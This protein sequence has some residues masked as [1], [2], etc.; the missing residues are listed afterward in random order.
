M[1]SADGLIGATYRTFR[2]RLHTLCR[3]GLARSV[4]TKRDDQ[5]V[6]RQIALLPTD[7]LLDALLLAS[8]FTISPMKFS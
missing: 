4:H 6:A 8:M 1:A 2:N 3:E 5:T 7:V